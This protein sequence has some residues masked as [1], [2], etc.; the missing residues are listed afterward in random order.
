MDPKLSRSKLDIIYDLMRAG[1]LHNKRFCTFCGSL[2]LF[3]RACE[4]EYVEMYNEEH[5]G[6]IQYK[7]LSCEDKDFYRQQCVACGEHVNII[8]SS[9]MQCVK[10][11]TLD[12]VI[13][14]WNR[15]SVRPNMVGVLMH[16]IEKRLN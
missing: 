12:M 10:I 16:P 1:I 15:S 5:F 14:M 6:L 11:G 4:K 8:A 3:T 7:N 13:D 9:F 2:M